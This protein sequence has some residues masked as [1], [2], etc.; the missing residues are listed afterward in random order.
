MRGSLTRRPTARRPRRLVTPPDC[1]RT[2]LNRGSDA[3]RMGIGRGYAVGATQ[4]VIELVAHEEYVPDSYEPD[5][6]G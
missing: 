6:Y 3:W 2:P 4:A 5:S 1:A